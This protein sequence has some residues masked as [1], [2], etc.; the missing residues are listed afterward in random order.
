MLCCFCC[1]GV[2]LAAGGAGSLV[3]VVWV[4]GCLWMSVL[5]L[6]VFSP[7]D[8]HFWCCCH[9]FRLWGVQR[10]RLCSCLVFSHAFVATAGLFFGGPQPCRPCRW[11]V[12][13]VFVLIVRQGYAFLRSLRKWY[14]VF[15]AILFCIPFCCSFISASLFVLPCC[16][17]CARHTHFLRLC[18]V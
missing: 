17:V 14:L 4:F 2:C 18:V 11:W 8:L 10:A 3:S 13:G 7:S 9:S 5:G 15:W 1:G 6:A 12:L 16:S